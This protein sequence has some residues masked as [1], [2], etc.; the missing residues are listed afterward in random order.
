MQRRLSHSS[1]T[2][3]LMLVHGSV[4]APGSL[5]FPRGDGTCCCVKATLAQVRAKATF[6]V[7]CVL[8]W[9]FPSY[10]TGQEHH[11]VTDHGIIKAGQDL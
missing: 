4:T 10:S 2:Q 3:H 1:R 6:L 5:S 8:P 7:A 11:A 9:I